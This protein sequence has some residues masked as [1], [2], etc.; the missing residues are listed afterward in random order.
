MFDREHK[1]LTLKKI[2]D[3][4][5]YPLSSGA[6]LLKSLVAPSYLDYERP[7]RSHFPTMRWLLLSRHTDDEIE[8]LYRRF[9]VET[10][11]RIDRGRL[12]RNITVSRRNG[13]VFSK[14]T[15]SHGVGIIAMLLSKGA[16]GRTFAVGIGGYFPG[17]SR[18]RRQSWT[19]C[20]RE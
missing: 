3:A 20:A 6:A 16:H 9:D 15:V 13:Y 1:P 18:T 4:F 17:S 12:K 8:K 10:G 14:H 5:R 11:Q 2:C 19:Q 7:T